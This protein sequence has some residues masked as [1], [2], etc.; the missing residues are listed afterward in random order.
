M[1]SEVVVNNVNLLLQN[2][3]MIIINKFMLLKFI[4]IMMLKHVLNANNKNNILSFINVK[5]NH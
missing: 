5:Q 1:D 3:I 4:M 2:I